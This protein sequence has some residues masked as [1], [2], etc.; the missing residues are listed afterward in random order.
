MSIQPPTSRKGF[1][2]VELAIVLVII[3]LIVGGVLTGQDLMKG[4]GVRATIDQL[5]KYHTATAVFHDKYKSLPGDLGIRDAQR[6]GFEV[7]GRGTGNGQ[8]DQD[9]RLECG[10]PACADERAFGAETAMFWRDL[11]DAGLIAA[12]TNRATGDVAGGAIADLYPGTLISYLPQAALQNGNFFA[13]FQA[14]GRNFI[15]LTGIRS[16]ARSNGAYQLDPSL[17]PQEAFNLDEKMD[18]G[19]PRRGALRA[20]D[21]TVLNS[22]NQGSSM[23]YASDGGAAS[24]PGAPAEGVCVVATGSDADQPYNTLTPAIAQIP[25]C[26]LKYRFY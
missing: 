11:Y 19:M 10:L 15:Q 26:I 21:N 22:L 9:G 20:L 24:T 18:D 1:T 7:A 3:G 25:S 6:F 12:L 14:Q 4:A 13:V 5:G 2:L 23:Q 8:G 17:S 16:I